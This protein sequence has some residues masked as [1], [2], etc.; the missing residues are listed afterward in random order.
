MNAITQFPSPHADA[1]T[2]ILVAAGDAS[3]Q[4]R[5][6]RL[7]S[8]I[9]QLEQDS[10][11]GLLCEAVQRSSDYQ[12]MSREDWEAAEDYAAWVEHHATEY[13]QKAAAYAQSMQG[14]A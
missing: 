12:V 13:A 3:K 1:V 11:L 7:L 10:D 4:E 2:A 5:V 14:A 8:A 9:Q 6:S